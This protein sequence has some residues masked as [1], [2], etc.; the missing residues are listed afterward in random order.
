MVLAKEEEVRMRRD[1]G[2]IEMIDEVLGH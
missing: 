2:R 1:G